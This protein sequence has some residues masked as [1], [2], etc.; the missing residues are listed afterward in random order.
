LVAHVRSVA[1]GDTFQSRAW[2]IAEDSARQAVLALR[3]VK[4]GEIQAGFDAWVPLA[5]RII[6]GGQRGAQSLA[7]GYF[8]GLARLEVGAV[9]KDAAAAPE[10]EVEF[11]YTPDGRKLSAALGAIPAKVWAAINSGRDFAEA[12]QFAGFAARRTATTSVMDSARFELTARVAAS[13]D[14]TGWRWRSAGTCGACLAMDDGAVRGADYLPAHPGCQCVPEP[15]FKGEP[16]SVGRTGRDR[17]DAMPK[18]A[19]DAVLGPDVAE[20]IRTGA[21]DWSDLVRH[22]TS[23]RW[24]RNITT[25]PLSQILGT[26][27]GRSN[28][29]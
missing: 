9:P 2:A 26:E 3:M 23:H 11:G 21:V 27:G 5:A 13:K 15:V 7:S 4:P 16:K 24:R 22:E 20:G 1:L 14:V 6:T 28:G 25:A 17:F 12:M 18:A 10:D 19:Q 8:R 29:G